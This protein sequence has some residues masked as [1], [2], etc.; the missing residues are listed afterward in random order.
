MAELSLELAALAVAAV[1]DLDVAAALEHTYEAHGDFDAALLTLRDGET[2]IARRPTSSAAAQEQLADVRA[3]AVLTPGMRS[4]LPFQV[5]EVLGSLA[6]KRE[7]VAVYTFLRGIPAD[8]ETL[9]PGTL[10]LVSLGRAI[11]A[12]HSLPK[13]PVEAAGMPSISASEARQAAA[14]T[15]ARAKETGRLPVTLDRRWSAAVDDDSLWQFQPTVIHGALGLASIITDGNQVRGVLGWSDLRVGDPARDLHWISSLDGAIA[16]GILDEYTDEAPGTVD[17]Q[18]RQRALLYA[19]LELARWLLHGVEASDAEIIADA[20]GMLDSLVDRIHRAPAQPLVHET[21][22]VLDIAE[23]QELLKEAAGRRPA[24]QPDAH[25]TGSAV[26]PGLVHE[27]TSGAPAGVHP[28]D[29]PHIDVDHA[30]E[31]DLDDDTPP[32][33]FMRTDSQR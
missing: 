27:A 14:Q 16:R 24:H 15:I 2:I 29:S 28:D 13:G 8:Q 30:A 1:P 33:D 20:E 6:E 25:D 9:E 19:E 10:F 17:R 18:L 21:L 23:V 3:L 31:D 32:N 11:A 7:R 22:P 5:S 26:L 12:I 4:R